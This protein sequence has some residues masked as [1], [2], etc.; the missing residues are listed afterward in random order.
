[1]SAFWPEGCLSERTADGLALAIIG[2]V[3]IIAVFTFRDY[4]LG[5]DDYVHAEY[6]GL[7]LKLYSS[8]FTDQRALSFVNLY[9]YGGGFDLL[10]ALAAKVLPFDLFE[11]RRLVGAVIGVVGLVLTWRLGR[12]IGG[13]LAGVIAVA[14]LATCPLYYGN[15][16]MNAKDSPFAVA[17]VFL[18]LSLVRAFEEYPKPSPITCAMLGCAAGLAIGTRVLGGLAI[19]N[20][21]AAL[22]VIFAIEARRDGVREAAARAGQFAL[23]FL[24]AL[25]LGYAV[26]AMVWPWSVAE[27]LNPLRAAEYFS[28]F[29]EKPWNEVFDGVVTSVPEM[30]RR[31]VPTLFLLKEP[32]IFLALGVSGA[33]G[34]LLA[35]FRRDVAPSRR[36]IFILLVFA[37][38]F[39]IALTVLTKPAMYNG[40]RHFV[41]LAPALAALG[42]LAGTWIAMRLWQ[43]WRPAVAVAAAALFAGLFLPVREMIRL[44]PYQYTHFNALAGGIRTA[45]DRY[46]LDYWGLSFK[47]AAQE[48][49]AKLTES[50]ATPTDKR[51]W[52][53]AICGPQRPAQVALGP[54][55]RVA[56]DPKGADFAMSMGEFY[57]S[58]LTEPVMVEVQREGVVYA[59]VYDIRGR[60]VTSLNMQSNTK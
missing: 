59:R 29:F 45:D 40:I 12:R 32:E 36:A 30:P 50:M 49:R 21:L 22:T 17:M 13:P 3:A 5:W 31:Y 8:G 26:M 28:H 33:A 23:S 4:G 39:P 60:T 56:W 57:C 43:T 9:A 1:M 37:A 58:Q 15:M 6:G 11:T 48:L 55:F 44:H 20:G 25:V 19:I 53:V 2:A 10:S 14:L 46:M 34:G 7:L 51:R 41:F 18:T 47:E 27:P 38:M 35:A 16:Y 24:P 42:G 52:R 54:E